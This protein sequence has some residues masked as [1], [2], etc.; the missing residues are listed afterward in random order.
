MNT[1]LLKQRILDLAIHGRL[2]P[3]NPDDEP[4]SQLLRRI[5]EEKEKL[6][7][8]GKI[9]RPKKSDAPNSA[10][11]FPFQIP[12]SWEWV[13]LG[14]ICTKF[15]TGPFGSMLHK[16][17]YTTNGIPVINPANII[18]GIIALAK[19]MNITNEKAQELSKYILYED[20]ILLARR[21]DLS[22][23]AIV[24]KES[25]GCL[26]GTGSFAMHLCLVNTIYF[27][28]LYNTQYIQNI[29]IAAS[30]GATMDNLNQN[31]L[32]K[33]LI[34]LPPL[35]EQQRI[36]S[37]IEKWFSL[38]DEIETNKESLQAAIKQ[39]KS[40]VLD[41]AIKGKLVSQNPN[42]EPASELIKRINKEKENLIA[43]GKIKRPKKSDEVNAIQEFP[44]EIPDSWEW[45]NLNSICDI[46]GGKRIPQGMSFAKEPTSHIYIRV[47]DMKNNTILSNGLKYIDD[48]VFEKIKKYLIAYSDLY[49]T[50]AGTIGEVGEVPKMFDGMNLTENAA[51]LTNI[52]CN[53]KYLMFVLMS[54]IAQEHFKSKFHQVAQPKLSIETAQTTLIPLPPL[55]EQTRI[56]SK[57]EEVFALLDEIEREL[58]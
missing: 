36:V 40:K 18:N 42:D 57:I 52:Q 14:E 30:V 20:D 35:A 43:Q 2:V 58:A 7:A 55:S 27:Q 21:G 13:R 12:D 37:A 6:I 25:A 38:I 54:T 31:V 11:E 47:T 34:P 22:K 33:I 15:S 56:V 24:T 50:I 10:Q 44:F 26:C 4:A 49:L 41:L 8:Q 32:S 39:T 3:Q 29:L 9:K 16:S 1:K 51:K 45:V 23:C 5:S 17:D 53:K 19:A 46:K 48:N 28:I